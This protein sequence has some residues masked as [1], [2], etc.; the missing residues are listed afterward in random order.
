MSRF[1][2]LSHTLWHCQYH[3]VWTP[4]YG[5]D[6]YN[7]TLFKKRYMGIEEGGLGLPRGTRLA[8]D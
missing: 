7:T 3:L 6:R 2:K 8:L 5:V 1:R 4:K